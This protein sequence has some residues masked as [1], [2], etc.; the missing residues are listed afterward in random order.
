MK[1]VT[2]V[3]KKIKTNVWVDTRAVVVNHNGRVARQIWDCIR[4]NTSDLVFN[5]V[6]AH[7]RIEHKM[8]ANDSKNIR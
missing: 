5:Q 8:I 6:V 3:V 4:K 7:A 1:Q 2:S